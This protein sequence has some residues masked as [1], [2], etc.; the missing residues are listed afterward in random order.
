MMLSKVKSHAQ[1]KELNDLTHNRNLSREL[2]IIEKKAMVARLEE[3]MCHKIQSSRLRCR[4]AKELRWNRST[5]F[6]TAVESC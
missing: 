2:N 3:K 4:Q 1:W 6:L 5:A